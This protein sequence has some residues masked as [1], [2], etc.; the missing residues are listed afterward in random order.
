MLA[1]DFRGRHVL[2][3]FE[4][5]DS[6]RHQLLGPG[7]PATSRPGSHPPRQDRRAAGPHPDYRIDTGPT[8]FAKKG[9]LSQATD[10][11]CNMNTNYE[12]TLEP[13]FDYLP[14]A[15]LAD[16]GQNAVI[17]GWHRPELPPRWST[18][19]T[20]K[21][22]P[23]APGRPSRRRHDAGRRAAAPM[24]R[25]LAAQPA[26]TERARTL[27]T[28][29]AKPTRIVPVDLRI[30][31]DDWDR[32]IVDVLGPQL[33]V[34]GPG[35]GKTEFL[36]E[37]GAAP[38]RVGHRRPCRSPDPCLLTTVRR[39]DRRE[40]GVTAHLSQPGRHDLSFLCPPPPRGPWGRGVR[41]AA[42]TVP[43]DRPGTNLAG[44]RANGGTKTPPA[45]PALYRSLLRSQ[46][47]AGE[48]GDFL[49]RCRERLLSS[50]DIRRQASERPQ[51]RALPDF[52]DR[53]DRRIVS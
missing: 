40:G 28:T 25:P 48:V 52:M 38:D 21:S 36:V 34:A 46:T 8:H 39:R 49:L 33:V 18:T 10:T 31:P 32:V 53:Y 50:D 23:T 3:W 16:A 22:A 2:A 4:Q 47:L 42:N 37:K 29:R 9:N 15:G 44:V 12:T 45:W 43:V 11:F 19:V 7:L 30:G 51:W 35:T 6:A 20:P 41:M 1:D 27:T 14:E 5:E 24:T 17:D 13:T 26:L